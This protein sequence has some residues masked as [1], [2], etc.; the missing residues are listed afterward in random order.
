M[1]GSDRRQLG[2]ALARAADPMLTSQ[3]SLDKRGKRIVA[4]SSPPAFSQTPA[5]IGGLIKG[6]RR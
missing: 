5:N 1:G 4:A 3:T 6:S 2:T